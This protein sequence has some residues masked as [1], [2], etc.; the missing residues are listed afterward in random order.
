M[1]QRVLNKL[2][3]VFNRVIWLFK[4][5]N[6]KVPRDPIGNWRKNVHGLRT[7]ANRNLFTWFQRYIV[8]DMQ[9]INKKYS[10]S[11]GWKYRL[12]VTKYVYVG[13]NSRSL[14]NVISYF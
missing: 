12:E 4:I 1:I 6:I 5:H 13:L 8:R 7:N 2:L 3:H 14:Y 10:L 9:L 11:T